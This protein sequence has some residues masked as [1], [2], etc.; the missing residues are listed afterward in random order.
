MT[1]GQKLGLQF[2][3]IALIAGGIGGYAYFGVIKKDEKK[4]RQAQHDLRLFAPQKLDE[5]QVDGG[6]PPADFTNLTVTFQGE[7]TRL[8]REEK[9]WR[10]VEPIRARAD[11]LVTDAMVSY[12][13]TAKFKSTLDE[14]PDQPTLAKY[15]LVKPVFEV[16]ASA[17]VNGE[18]RKV[19]IAG[20][21]E[22]TFDGS[23]FVR[24][25]DEKPVFT[26][27]GGA[28][29]TLARTLFDLRDKF[30]MS[31]DEK[32]I[33]ALSM[34]STSNAWKVER[35]G[36]KQW[37]M[38]E[39]T[40]EPADQNGIAASLNAQSQARAQKFFDDSP[41]Q[42]KALGVDAP[43]LTVFAQL[44]GG[45]QVKL[46][47]K[48]TERDGGDSMVVLR[49]DDDGSTT[50]AEIG[51]GAM[52]LDRSAVDMRD[53]TVVQFRTEQVAKIVF[54]DPAA[55]GD[56]VVKKDAADAS[57]ESWR[58][59]APREGKA[60]IFRIT[61]AL[62]TLANFKAL[63]WGEE[64]PKDWKKYGVDEK[65]K[66][67]AVFGDDDVELARLTIG[68][69]VPNTPSAYFVRGTRNQVLQ[70]DGSRFGEFPFV[71]TDALDL[72]VDGGN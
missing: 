18:L 37:R 27:E 34:K 12:L 35:Q 13:Q 19:S 62:W 56:V 43:T 58:V 50:L 25:N 52:A 70:S 39:P 49:E 66:W 33:K 36:P 22:N 47:V 6:S 40:Q 31:L 59:V 15:G 2:V 68:S 67:I 54:H 20:G 64:K 65:S 44:E 32:Q 63:A 38:L 55:G 5:R 61:G 53:K 3:V 9:E 24:R 11:K 69:L 14:N 29:Y 41:A 26:A 1:Q 42:R 16:T 17:V 45:H 48:R 21:I 10:I 8:E 71:V 46:S 51:E 30:P 7:T 23:V 72:P 28:R 57:V 60:K 4:E